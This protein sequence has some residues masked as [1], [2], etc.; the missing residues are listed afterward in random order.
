MTFG[1]VPDAPVTGYGYIQK[2]ETFDASP[3]QPGDGE[4]SSPGGGFRI[5][6]FVEKPDL[7]SAKAYVAS[8]EYLWNTG[9]FAWSV[10]SLRTALQRFAPELARRLEA[11]R[12]RWQVAGEPEIRDLYELLPNISIDYALLEHADNVLVVQGEHQRI[13]IG[14]LNALAQIWPADEDQNAGRGMWVSRNSARNIVYTSG[15]LVALV[16]VNDTIVVVTD[17]VVL[18]CARDQS[19]EVGALVQELDT[20]MQAQYL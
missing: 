15:R 3:T 17:D 16:G 1:V 8:G 5:A 11:I 4:S 12:I 9:T 14:D 19:Q 6:A 7:D 2:G 13:D 10:K 18:V 20:P